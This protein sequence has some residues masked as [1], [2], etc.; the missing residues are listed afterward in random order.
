LKDFLVDELSLSYEEY[1][2]ESTAGIN[3]Q[4]RLEAMRMQSS[5]A[6]L[7]MTSED[8]HADETKHARENVTHEVGFFQGCLGFK[9]AIVLKEDGCS[10]FSNIVG[11]GQIR[12]PA[13]DISARFEDVRK[14]LRREGIV[15]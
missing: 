15:P 14:V 7:V 3:T 9:R 5:F 12:F 2:R 8:E 6:F 13:G 11:L 10:E 1:N 4:E